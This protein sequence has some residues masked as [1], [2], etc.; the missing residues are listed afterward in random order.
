MLLAHGLTWENLWA[1]SWW[2]PLTKLI[3]GLPLKLYDD[4]FV[5]PRIEV[6]I[7]GLLCLGALAF[8]G[9]RLFDNR[10]AAVIA[11]M[12]GVFLPQRWILSVVPLSDIFGY[13]LLLTAADAAEE[14]AEPL[15]GLTDDIAVLRVQRTV[16]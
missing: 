1:P 16:R 10:L 12:L 6:G 15:G 11:A 7:A 2:P 4:L 8:L 9:H 14:R 13:A 3:M 5:T